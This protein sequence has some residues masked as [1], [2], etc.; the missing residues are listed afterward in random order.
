MA[1]DNPPAK[2]QR[3]RAKI[4]DNTA[5]GN[6]DLSSQLVKSDLKESTRPVG[7][8]RMHR[9]TVDTWKTAPSLSKVDSCQKSAVSR[10]IHGLLS[11]GVSFDGACSIK[12]VVPAF[13]G[14]GWAGCP[15]CDCADMVVM[16]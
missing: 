5:C 14:S 11:L 7:Q 15:V 16:I 6:G 1:D 8:R 3:Q 10:A 4:A 12:S 2:L 9:T 13:S